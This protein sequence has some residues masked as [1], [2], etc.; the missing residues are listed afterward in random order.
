MALPNETALSLPEIAKHL[1][2]SEEY[3]RKAVR[4]GTLPSTKLGRL[5]FIFPSDVK[6][7]PQ[8]GPLWRA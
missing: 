7:H 6:A 1:P 4:A 5:H 2:V 3:V 8:L